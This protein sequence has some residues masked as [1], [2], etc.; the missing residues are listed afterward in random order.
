[1]EWKWNGNKSPPRRGIKIEWNGMETEWKWNGEIM[2]NS[3]I[4]I[5]FWKWNGM[6]MEWKWN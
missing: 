2:A 4:K 5:W 1:M 6:E 3:D